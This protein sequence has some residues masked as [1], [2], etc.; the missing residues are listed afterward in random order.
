V[1]AEILT[2]KRLQEGVLVADLL[3]LPLGSTEVV[4]CQ[5]ELR[6]PQQGKIP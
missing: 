6:K 3:K 4:P 5:A 2:Q 1:L